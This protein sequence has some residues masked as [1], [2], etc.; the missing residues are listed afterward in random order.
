MTAT[1]ESAINLLTPTPFSGFPKIA[2]LHRECVITEKID[3]T[4]AQIFVELDGTVRAG[5]RTSWCTPEKDNFGFAR[6]VK[7]HED[8]LRVGLGFG[9]HFGE[10]WGQGIGRRYGMSEK[11]FSL[12]NVHQWTVKGKP[13][14][15]CDV[16][17]IICRGVFSSALVTEAIGKLRTN[18]SM[19]APGFMQPEGV[20][21]FHTASSQLYKVTLEND[22][23]PKGEGEES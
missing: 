5:K 2:R 4:N 15:C 1:D 23:K 19:A 7:E 17:P 8:E 20:V 6:W 14:A 22:E 3:G 18:G 12:F 16:V 9:A 11:K 13:P 21:I 10:W